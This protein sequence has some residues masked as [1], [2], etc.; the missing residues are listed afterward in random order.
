MTLFLQNMEKPAP[1]D[2]ELLAEWLSQQREPAFHALVAR[3]AGLVHATAKRTCGDESMAAEA[4]QLTFIALAQ[5]AKTL[6]SCNSLGGW[7][8]LT[9]MMQAKNLIRKSQRENRK[10]QLLQTT[11]EAESQS[12]PSDI[13]QEMQPVLDA[14]LAAL[15]ENDREALLLRFYRSLTIREIAATLGIATDAAQKRIDRATERLRGKLARRGVQTSGTLSAALLAGF[16]ADAQAALPIA[17]LASKAI[18]AGAVSSFSLAAI[19]TTI[20]ALM[21][22][23]SFIPTAVALIVAGVW[24]GT[25]YQSLSATEARN[26]RLRNDIATARSFSIPV[27]GKLAKDDDPIDWKK[28]AV[29]KRDG[30]ETAR[31][32]TRLETMAQEDMIAT[33]DQIAAID[34]NKDRRTEIESMVVVYLQTINPEWV[35]KHFITDLRNDEVNSTLSRSSALGLWAKKDLHNATIW[36]DSQISAGM[37]DSKQLGEQRLS[38]LRLHFET[39]LFG[40]LLTADPAAAAHRLGAISEMQRAEVMSSGSS[41]MSNT[42][43]TEGGHLA[44]ANLI[45]DQLPPNL[46][47]SLLLNGRPRNPEDGF[48]QLKAYLEKIEATPAERISCLEEFSGNL[49][50]EMSNKRK[51]TLADIESMRENFAEISPEAVDTVTGRSLAHAVKSRMGPMLFPQ[52][53]EIAVAILESSGRDDVLAAF[54]ESARF[55]NSDKNRGRELAGRISDAGRRAEILKRFE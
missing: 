31:L 55:E 41:T 46:Q 36:L 25:K 28:L 54:L 47:S 39:Q 44:F 14:A 23:S 18:A 2:P 27:G 4:S 37:L 9:A 29:E 52:A 53:S 51:V 15:S 24:M 6:T 8:H 19:I 11:M 49:I 1:S 35:L 50:R 22:T 10:R 5:K 45:R 38:R 20:A 48:P 26:A 12:H 43:L 42:P 13:W 34:V 40:V 7:L 16:A 30:P 3:Y 33:L 32:M 21:K 17:I